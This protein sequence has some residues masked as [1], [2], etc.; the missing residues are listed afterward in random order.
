M[1]SAANSASLRAEPA[2]PGLF[3][4]LHSSGHCTGLA[5]KD[6]EHGLIFTLPAPIDETPNCARNLVHINGIYIWK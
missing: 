6:R 1:D 5:G 4:R 2:L 3:D